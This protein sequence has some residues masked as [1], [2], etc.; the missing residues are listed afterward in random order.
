MA[1]ECAWII[2]LVVGH[3]IPSGNQ[4]YKCITFCD[5]MLAKH[6]LSYST[7]IFTTTFLTGFCTPSTARQGS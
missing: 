3:F 4:I 7:G 1:V 5:T 6:V 2:Y